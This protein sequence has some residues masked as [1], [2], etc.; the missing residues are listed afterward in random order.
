[1][2]ERGKFDKAWDEVAVN[3][4]KINVSDMYMLV[5]SIYSNLV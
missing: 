2:A 5:E 1:M 4:K 3:K